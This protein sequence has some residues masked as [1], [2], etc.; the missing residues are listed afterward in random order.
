MMI[1]L[2][3]AASA[4]PEP[5]ALDAVRDAAVRHFANPSSPHAQGTA[6]RALLESC[7]ARVAALLGGGGEVVFTSGAS[8][9]NT[10]ILL[11]CAMRQRRADT[12]GKALRIVTSAL[13][14]ASVHDQ[15]RL[16]EGL[17]LE[18][19]TVRPGAD[20]R[21]D[22]QRIVDSLNEETALVSVMH[23]NNET[24]AVQPVAEIAR[25]V[26][27]Y[28]ARRGRPILIHTD[29][30]Q[31]FCKLPFSPAAGGVSALGVDAVSMSGHKIGGPRGIGALWLARGAAPDFLS[32]GGGQEGGRRP[33]TE[34][35]PGIC[36][37]AA[38]AEKRAARQGEDLEAAARRTAAFLAAL[39]V[40]PGG[41][42]FP[43]QREGTE[44]HDL[45]S[46]YIVSFAFPPLPGEIVVRLADSRGISISTGAACSSRK[47]SRT[48]VLESMGVSAAAARCAVR[49]SFGPTTADEDIQGLLSVLS[50]DVQRTRSMAGRA[51]S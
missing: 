10:A 45:F 28:A 1:Y 16:M 23:V 49:A 4:P 39:R 47:K 34:N 29:A 42:V 17:G 19:M 27:E 38:A 30:A 46:P 35:I 26:R 18:C 22:P 25:A 40:L 5:E 31:G 21:V 9:S 51:G 36:G 37:F 12:R 15:A 41:R 3:W 6:A 2:D 32:A 50:G 43:D 48:R 44:G 24:G 11:S 14:H 33:G 13:E 8:E 7:R 20:G